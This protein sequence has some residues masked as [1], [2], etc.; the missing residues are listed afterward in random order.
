MTQIRANRNYQELKIG[1]AKLTEI[2]FA[3]DTLIFAQD[4]ESMEGLLWTTV[5]ISGIYG[6]KLNKKKCVEINNKETESIQFE[7]GETI[8]KG[9]TKHILEL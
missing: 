3:D 5:L 8:K 6:L 4:E 1:A 7:D 9:S 2:M